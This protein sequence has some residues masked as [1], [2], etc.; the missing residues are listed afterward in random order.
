MCRV[1]VGDKGINALKRALTTAAIK[2]HDGNSADGHLKLSR[3]SNIEATQFSVHIDGNM[4][5]LVGTYDINPND[6][7]HAT[8]E[9]DLSSILSGM[10][11][12]SNPREKA[13]TAITELIQNQL[14]DNQFNFGNKTRKK[15]ANS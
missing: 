3:F 9:F 12:S 11:R 1:R 6:E 4:A 2:L 10:K 13:Q 15:I 8:E 5:T 14:S 7:Y